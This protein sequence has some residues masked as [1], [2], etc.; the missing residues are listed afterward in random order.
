MA[1][2]DTKNN[3][4]QLSNGGFRYISP[5]TDFGFKRLFGDPRIMKGFLNA[6]FDSKKLNIVI[7][8][9]EYIDKD[10]LGTVKKN[11]GVIYDLRCKTTTGE[12]IIV[13]MQNE[14]QD[15]FENR[16]IYYLA[17]AVSNQ[18]FKKGH[19]GKPEEKEDWDFAIHRVIGVFIM[20]FYDPNDSEKIS[21]NCWTNVDTHEISSDR[22]EYW[23]VQLPY[24]R[25]HNMKK[26]DCT[27]KSDYWLYNIANMDTMEELAFKEK[28]SDFVY[29]SELAEFRAMSIPEQ[30]RY[31]RQIDREVVWKNVMDRKYRFG[32]SD[33]KE[34]GR[35]EGRAEGRVEGRAEGIAEGLAVGEKQAKLLIA[36]S[37][38]SFGKMTIDEI[39]AATN[40][41]PDEIAKI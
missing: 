14:G 7:E 27:T 23:K 20:N 26:E 10:E 13:E 11:R 25:K 41:T 29:L 3:D 16:I 34:E 1:D 17:R 9:L 37:L 33:G 2:T 19:D 21:R 24:F 30:D 15:F 38:K 32:F 22:Q 12:E 40:L 8:D 35:A 18:G 31:I 28:D 39:A 6:L 4:N 5:T 36:R